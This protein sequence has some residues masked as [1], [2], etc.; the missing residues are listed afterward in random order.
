M[1]RPARKSETAPA[2]ERG[3]EG[4]RPAGAAG[5]HAAILALQQTAGNRGVNAL[6]ALPGGLANGPLNSPGGAARCGQP[7][8]TETRA[9]MEA[10]LGADFGQVRV[11]SGPDA[12]A[13]AAARQAAAFTVGQDV[14][15]GA[16]AP[17]AAT[18]IGQ[19]L[20]AHELAHVI[21]QQ[22]GQPG[23]SPPG[24]QTEQAANA[25]ATAF[26]AHG[27]PVQVAGS[28]APGPACLTLKELRERAAPLVN[29]L[30]PEARQR[31]DQ[32]LD[33]VE[34][35][36]GPDATVP[37]PVEQMA[38]VVLPPDRPTRPP[39]PPP[40]PPVDFQQAS[41][42]LFGLAAP[43]APRTES[44]APRP[45]GP[46]GED[47]MLKMLDS[48]ANPPEPDA[49]PEPVRPPGWAAVPQFSEARVKLAGSPVLKL[50]E[51]VEAG[52]I[53]PEQLEQLQQAYAQMTGPEAEAL[54]KDPKTAGMHALLQDYFTKEQRPWQ[55]FT[56]PTPEVE[57][58]LRRRLGLKAGEYIPQRRLDELASEIRMATS[59]SAAERAE[60]E[61][62]YGRIPPEEESL[63]WQHFLDT[64]RS[65]ARL[66][67]S[68]KGPGEDQGQACGPSKLT[69]DQAWNQRVAREAKER[70]E[71]RKREN[72]NP[73][74]V[75]EADAAVVA[76]AMDPAGAGGV[77]T[78]LYGVTK[79]AGASEETA[80]SVGRVGEVGFTVA[81]AWAGIRGARGS[82]SRGMGAPSPGFGETQWGAPVRVVGE[83]NVRPAPGAPVRP[84]TLPGPV[85]TG[86]PAPAPP[87]RAE[88]APASEPLGHGEVQLQVDPEPPPGFEPTALTAADI[89]TGRLWSARTNRY[90]R[91]KAP[92]PGTLEGLEPTSQAPSG[93][94]TTPSTASPPPSR[95]GAYGEIDLGPIPD[96]RRIKLYLGAEPIPLTPVGKG[97][98]VT[99]QPVQTP[100]GG[101]VYNRPRA[102]GRRPWDPPRGMSL[103][104]G[105][106][107]PFE[108]TDP[109]LQR[110]LDGNPPIG[111]DGKIVELHHG[112]QTMTGP[113]EEYTNT[114][115]KELP[116]HERE[117]DSRIDRGEF[118]G[119]RERYWTTRAREYL[120]LKDPP[121]RRPP[122]AY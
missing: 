21:Q 23:A 47:A 56:P 8:D 110:M 95:T 9:A 82:A 102:E 22:R 55:N 122:R 78:G 34:K 33:T 58:A 38:A 73:Y 18:P 32:G 43:A 90:P 97:W 89:R 72:P 94:Q 27:G 44:A 60:F 62:K 121:T 1:A 83:A 109:N 107:Q 70:R 14:V 77:G 111:K 13:A 25:A 26:I 40:K 74:D 81:G 93:Q 98:G 31:V 19:Y 50:H 114:Q 53:P 115:H 45:E 100:S 6:L 17:P 79:A 63:L 80:R 51:D 112:T 86:E 119:Q 65:T 85:G 54:A 12:A 15:L 48:V 69:R 42:Q 28:S 101:R 39:P 61:R 36:V 35:F 16:E 104:R 59:P 116:L 91:V 2:R 7:L 57:A 113:L 76:K 108:W 37:K 10:R 49:E 67:P 106:G 99:A 92:R 24:E 30:P 41:Q 11:H 20:L 29:R 105:A 103:N 120:G 46:T 4:P 5:P 64:S 118:A 87:Q 88:P 96:A 3:G 52:R 68:S 84:V 71:A 117:W 75:M 66:D